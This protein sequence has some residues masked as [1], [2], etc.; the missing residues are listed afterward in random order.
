MCREREDL[1]NVEK[2]SGIEHCP[3]ER[4]PHDAKEEHVLPTLPVGECGIDSVCR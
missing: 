4:T 1:G 2:D 3:I